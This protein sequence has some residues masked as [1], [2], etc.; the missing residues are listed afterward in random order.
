MLPLYFAVIY[1]LYGSAKFN[2]D[3]D[4]FKATATKL[5]MVM[6]TNFIAAMTV[7]VLSIVLINV[8]VPGSL[9]AMLA[10]ILFPLNSCIN[11]LARTIISNMKG[12][13]PSNPATGCFRFLKRMFIRASRKV[14]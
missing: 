14:F 5:G 1:R 7:V 9:E 3:Y 10:F 2:H 4:N 6:I 12:K 11:P 13:C 8:Y